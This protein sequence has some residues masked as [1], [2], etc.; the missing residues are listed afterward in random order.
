MRRL[1]LAL[2]LAPAVV[3]VS[4][5]QPGSGAEPYPARTIKLIAPGPPGAS[6]DAVTRLVADKLSQSMGKAVVV[7]NRPGANGVI[8]IRTLMSANPDGYTLGLLYSDSLVITPFLSKK[9]LLDPLK[10]IAYIS[11][12]GITSPFIIAVHPSVPAQSFQDLVQLA[13]SEPKRIRYSTYGLGSGPQLSFESLAAKVGADLLHVPY[14]GGAA[15]Y[16]AAVAGEVDAV[17]M[18]SSTEL[19]KAGRLRALAVGGNKRAADFPNIPT[20]GELG[21]PTE[22][23]TPVVY[24]F[25]AP[26]GTPSEIIDQLAREFKKITEMPDIAER[27]E[28]VA[29]YATWMDAANYRETLARMIKTNRPVIDRLGLATE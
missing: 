4:L 18:T 8:A 21:Y 12:I 17:A 26:V 25:A 15:S 3:G 10:D 20:L 5:A 6:T 27:F 7:E 29:T 1:L 24:G 13:K 14:K 11:A 28:R 16:H 9:P 22:I 23:F 19:I 2:A